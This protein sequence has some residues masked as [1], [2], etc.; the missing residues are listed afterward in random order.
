MNIIGTLIIDMKILIV[1]DDESLTAIISTALEKEGFTALTCA[2][3]RDATNR[4]KEDMPDLV[5][6]DQVLPD[7]S[8]NIVLKQVKM[9]AATKNI[10]I[11]M[12]SNFSQGEIVNQAI[13]DGAADYIYKYQVEISD[14]VNKVKDALK[15]PAE[16][17]NL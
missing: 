15:P 17:T 6:L 1:D 14:I 2:T 5:L 3:G 9:D 12:L 10:P 7:V 13:Q 16:P 8:G 4:I 11:L